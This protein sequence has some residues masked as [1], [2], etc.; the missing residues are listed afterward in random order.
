MKMRAKMI[1]RDVQTSD[2]QSSVKLEVVTSG[3]PENS[4]YF[5]YTPAG[6]LQLSVL[7][8][9]LVKDIKVGD[10][11]YVDLIPA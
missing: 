5:K 9:E 7:K 3:S 10:E 8:P 1:C 11:F 4:E 6:T 2:D